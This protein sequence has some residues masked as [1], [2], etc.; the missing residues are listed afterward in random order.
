MYAKFGILPLLNSSKGSE[1]MHVRAVTVQIQPG[2][3]QEAIDVYKD[4]VVPAA[5]AQKAFQGAYLMPAASSGKGLSI[6]V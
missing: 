5:K 2:K 1:I 6:T 3:M 4:S